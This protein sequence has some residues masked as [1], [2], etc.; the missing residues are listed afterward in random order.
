[1]S[2][3]ASLVL[4]PLS[5][6]QQWLGIY[7]CGE[8][9][10]TDTAYAYRNKS[11]MEKRPVPVAAVRDLTHYCNVLLQIQIGAYTAV[12]LGLNCSQRQVTSRQ[13]RR[14]Q[15]NLFDMTW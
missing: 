12:G 15:V 3:L 10:Q 9:I 5:D 2:A 6:R 11:V 7:V 14:C 13:R 1:M 8:T 4:I